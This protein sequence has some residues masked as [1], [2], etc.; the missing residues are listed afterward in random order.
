MDPDALSGSRADLAGALRRLR[1]EAGLSGSRL[2]GR[3]S[4]S[5]SK[6][7]KIENG[8]IVPSVIDVDR[9]LKALNVSGDEADELLG[10]VRL[11]N[12][13]FHDDRSSL[14]RGLHFRQDDLAALEESAEET[15]YFLPAMITGLL[16]TPD[17]ATASLGSVHVDFSLALAKRLERQQILFD[18]KHRFRFL[19]T[20]AAVRWPLC[21]PPQMAAQ[22]DRISDLSRLPNVSVGVL[23]L[24]KRVPETPLNTFTVYDTRLVTAETLGGLIVMRDP[25]DVAFHLD[26]FVRFASHALVEDEAREFLAAVAQE[27]RSA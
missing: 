13:E 5:Q 12:T 19:L 21:T 22:V 15:R 8:K 3:A 4:M 7:S 18:E 17:Y 1:T 11:A 2:A 27:F 20:E 23:P 9:I 26:V 25:R 6:I 10:L 24:V 14:R 16:H